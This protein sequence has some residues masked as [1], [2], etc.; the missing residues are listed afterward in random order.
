MESLTERVLRSQHSAGDREGVIREIACRVY[1]YPRRRC[2]WDEESSSE[3]FARVFPKVPGMVDRFKDIGRPFESY[4]ASMLAFQ[5]RTFVKERRERE[6]EWEVAA[7]PELWGPHTVEAGPRDG[8]AC[9]GDD[10]PPERPI[11]GPEVS[12]EE[13]DRRRAWEEMDPAMRKVF[14]IA[15]DGGIH[16]A[17]SCRRF[18]VACLT[19]A[20]VLSDTDVAAISRISGTR[21]EALF[22]AVRKLR[23]RAIGRSR[24]LELFTERRN[25]AYSG[26][27]LAD[28]R[29]RREIDP[30]K[31]GELERKRTRLQRTLLACH[32]KI[33]RIRLAPSHQQIAEVL[34]MPKASVDSTLHRLKQRA[35]AFYPPTHEQYA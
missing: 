23:S 18:L 7:D 2:R 29:L 11:A 19:S 10:S 5:V 15:E 28:N 3:Y 30:K 34:H 4:L 26:L 13:V 27:L 16:S 33:S 17:C 20:H 1:E 25:R 31:R 32:Q 9:Q 8:E 12:A 22:E 21:E 6:L 35:K 24:R 14:D